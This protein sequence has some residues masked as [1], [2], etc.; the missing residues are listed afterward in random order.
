MATPRAVVGP[1]QNNRLQSQPSLNAD[2]GPQCHRASKWS[3]KD[4]CHKQEPGAHL[5]SSPS[6]SVDNSGSALGKLSQRPKAPGIC[7]SYDSESTVS[8]T[9]AWTLC[10]LGRSMSTEILRIGVEIDRNSRIDSI[11]RLWVWRRFEEHEGGPIA[12][13]EDSWSPLWIHIFDFS[14]ETIPCARGTAVE[15]AMETDA[16]GKIAYC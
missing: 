5:V 7:S 15:I 13:A 8:L 12:S 11:N 1:N 3:H 4:L 6:G 16:A 10:P 2:N 14:G 9:G